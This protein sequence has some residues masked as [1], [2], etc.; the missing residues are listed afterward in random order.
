MSRSAKKPW[1][2]LIGSFTENIEAVISLVCCYKMV[3]VLYGFPG[4]L[5]IWCPFIA[6]LLWNCFKNY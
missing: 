3:G 4:T 1:M 5:V 6:K 2:M